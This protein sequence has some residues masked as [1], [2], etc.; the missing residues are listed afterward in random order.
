MP[1][2]RMIFSAG[3]VVQLLLLHW[4]AVLL[5]LSIPAPGVGHTADNGDIGAYPLTQAALANACRN[6]NNQRFFLLD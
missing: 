3:C 4:H 6:G 1:T 2:E 5:P